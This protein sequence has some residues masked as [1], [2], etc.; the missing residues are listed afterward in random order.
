MP[1]HYLIPYVPLKGHKDPDFK[2]LA[3]GESGQRGKVLKDNLSKGSYLFFHTKIGSSKYITCYIVVDRILPGKKAQS[4]SSINCD[5]QY[6]DWL[7]IGDK[8]KSKRLRK[9]IYFIKQLAKKLSLNID[10]EPFNSGR[11]TELAVIGSA[12]RSHRQLTDNDVSILLDEIEKY[13]ENVKIENPPDVQYHL[14]F[15]DESEKIIPMDEVHRLK[16]SEIQKLLRKNPSV[17]EKDARVID[18]E[19]VLP[20]GDRLDLVLEA[21]D[22]SLIVAELKGPDK[23]TD[24]IPT[25]VASYVRDIEKEYPTRKIRKMIVCDG[26]V[27]PKLQKACESL[28]IEIVVYGVKLDCFK[29]Q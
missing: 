6:D 17:I 13:E 24:E 4:N 27:S 21:V 16:E 5:G 15:Y 7:F 19:K 3:Y 10:F 25:Q 20:D 26:K 11:K 12:T 9:P 18:Y 23:L 1:K 28:G 2:E 22:G 8:N 14:Y 29:L